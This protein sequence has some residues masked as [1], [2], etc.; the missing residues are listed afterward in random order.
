MAHKATN[1]LTHYLCCRLASS[2]TDWK[3]EE[4][5]KEEEEKEEEEE[6][7]TAGRTVAVR[8]PVSRGSGKVLDVVK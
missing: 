2:N 7:C 4:E 8:L 6:G 1:H 3:E 5:E